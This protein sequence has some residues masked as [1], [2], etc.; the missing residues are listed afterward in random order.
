VLAEA[1]VDVAAKLAQR[2]QR[3]GDGFHVRDGPRGVLAAAARDVSAAPLPYR[4][5]SAKP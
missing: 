2:G 3:K 1:L 4:L 5:V